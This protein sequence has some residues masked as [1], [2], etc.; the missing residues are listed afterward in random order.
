M[1]GKGNLRFFLAEITLGL[2]D[3][4][5][6]PNVKSGNAVRHPVDCEHIGLKFLWPKIYTLSCRQ[7]IRPNP[8]PSSAQDKR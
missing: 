3:E 6:L 8:A 5:R 1:E 7:P 2:K 4:V